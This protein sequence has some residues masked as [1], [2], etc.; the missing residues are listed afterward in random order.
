MSAPWNV[1]VHREGMGIIANVNEKYV[2]ESCQKLLLLLINKATQR[3]E[4]TWGNLHH[5]C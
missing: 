2:E 1:T 5:L 4:Y 3:A